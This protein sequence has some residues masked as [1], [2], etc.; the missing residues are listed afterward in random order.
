M[1]NLKKY[2]LAIIASLLL[3]IGLSLSPPPVES[4]H[5]TLVYRHWRR[6]WRYR[7]ERYKYYYNYWYYLNKRELHWTYY[8]T[9]YDI[10]YPRQS[11]SNY[12]YARP[13]QLSLPV[14]FLVSSKGYINSFKGLDYGEPRLTEVIGTKQQ[15]KDGIPPKNSKHYAWLSHPQL[16]NYERRGE[17]G[18]RSYNGK[19]NNLWF[20]N[21]KSGTPASIRYTLSLE[22]S[23]I[24][25]DRAYFKFAK[26]VTDVGSDYWE[27]SKEA[28]LD[29]IDLRAGCTPPTAA[30]LYS[31]KKYSNVDSETGNTLDLLKYTVNAPAGV[32]RPDGGIQSW[33]KLYQNNTY[34][35]MFEGKYSAIKGQCLQGN[36]TLTYPSS[37][38]PRVNFTPVNTS[39]VAGKPTSQLADRSP[40][41]VPH[42]GRPPY[43]ALYSIKMPLSPGILQFSPSSANQTWDTT[44][45][46]DESHLNVGNFKV[47]YWYRTYT[48]GT[49]FID[50]K[51]KPRFLGFNA[52]D[53]YTTNKKQLY[54]VVL[55]NQAPTITMQGS[56]DLRYPEA[57]LS[58]DYIPSGVTI[59]ALGGRGKSISG[60]TNQ[61]SFPIKDSN[62]YSWIGATI[63][64]STDLRNYA[65]IETQSSGVKMFM[66]Y[67]DNT[68]IIG[69]RVVGWKNYPT[70]QFADSKNK[71]GLVLK[72]PG[73]IKGRRKN[74][75]AGENKANFG[76]ELVDEFMPGRKVE[77]DDAGPKRDKNFLPRQKFNTYDTDKIRYYVVANDGFNNTASSLNNS[78]LT[79]KTEKER[80]ANRYIEVAVLDNDAPSISVEFGT[81]DRILATKIEET[82]RDPYGKAY[83]T[84][85][86]AKN[87]AI[88][89]YERIGS[90][91]TKT[92]D[93]AGHIDNPGF[94]NA[95]PESYYFSPAILGDKIKLYVVPG[96]TLR[97]SVNAYDNF[98]WTEKEETVNGATVQANVLAYIEIVEKESGTQ[99]LKRDFAFGKKTMDEAAEEAKQI[100]N[101][102]QGNG[103][104][105]KRTFKNNVRKGNTYASRP[106]IQWV[107]VAPTTAA[108]YQLVFSAKDTAGN[109]QALKFDFVVKEAIHERWVY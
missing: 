67:Y 85:G 4:C 74:Y 95:G 12:F 25:R 55:D 31:K 14:T 53:A 71:A 88:F 56:K 44:Y 47:N 36:F 69:G 20:A 94:L 93:I 40:H 58:G 59:T 7:Q 30:Y 76:L 23:G 26:E 34:T 48:D 72:S 82:V 24:E 29:T 78:L 17:S 5:V 108:T 92:V 22:R 3:S 68:P 33:Y 35:P 83:K 16:F 90:V 8:A 32:A 60:P 109:V 106:P 79:G 28:K 1:K 97:I 86:I 103:V 39:G 101:F 27:K 21:A 84:D 91:L 81:E 99:F 98:W 89:S 10:W 19:S 11:L 64:K 75:Y 52:R 107:G 63:A 105:P 49:K 6:I 15:A 41:S 46:K 62:K 102:A 77:F 37:Y 54:A 87:K 45:F 42:T 104:Y 43:S 80:N 57:V 2:F 51:N 70:N 38:V 18:V 61:F 96:G 9:D 73:Y 13:K 66:Q 50:K 65:S 100:A